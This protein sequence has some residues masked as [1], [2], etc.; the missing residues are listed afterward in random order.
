MNMIDVFLAQLQSAHDHIARVLRGLND[1][2]VV[3]RP[4]ANAHSIGFSIWHALRAW[5]SYYALI[6]RTESLYEK[7]NWA[8][9]FGFDMR[10]KGVGGAG[11]G[12]GFTPED[13]AEMKLNVDVLKEF[14]ERTW[15]ITRNTLGKTGDDGLMRDVVVSWWNP[16]TTT[17]ARVLSHIVAH[18]YVHIG[19][20][21][22]IRGLLGK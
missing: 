12:T 8:Q 2:Q 21:E 7:E 22:Y 10:G 17:I 19:E 20:A 4:S 9:R 11:V 1:E 6:I 18:T 5:D 3:Y 16:S 13:I 15:D 14:L